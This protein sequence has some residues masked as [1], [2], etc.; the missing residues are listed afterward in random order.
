VELAGSTLRDLH[1]DVVLARGALRRERHQ[2]P[3]VRLDVSAAR[4]RL[5]LAL[6]AYEEALGE[7]GLPMP[8]RLRD[9]LRLLRAL[10]ERGR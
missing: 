9:E 4:H 5:V 3:A 10:D 8:Y 1:T 7:V 2:Q 6:R